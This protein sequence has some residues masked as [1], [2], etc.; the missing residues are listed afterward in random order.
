MP[1][2]M[3]PQEAAERQAAYAA[4]RREY[5]RQVWP[6]LTRHREALEREKEGKHGA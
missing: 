3:T 1:D 2:A 4:R 6:L 5:E